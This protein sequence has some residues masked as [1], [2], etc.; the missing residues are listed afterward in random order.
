M[1]LLLFDIDGTLI[2]TFRAGQRAADRAFHK[3]FGIDNVMNGIRTDGLTDP[4]I[5]K[6]M[7]TNTFDREFNGEESESFYQSY[8]DCLNEELGK[9]EKINILPGVFELLD[10]LRTRSDCILALGTGNI[11]EGAW[12]KLEHAGLRSYFST[13]GFGSD[14]EKRNKLIEIAIQKA[15]LTYNNSQQFEKVFVIGDTPH[16]ITHGRTAGA[17]TVGV[18]TGNYSMKELEDSQPDFLFKDL[19]DKSLQNGVF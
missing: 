13:G 5:L 4:L 19:T 3:L 14:S 7:F 8:I 6:M 16:D 18:G 1:K 17:L 15:S 9:L 11:E 12:L 10:H 2:N